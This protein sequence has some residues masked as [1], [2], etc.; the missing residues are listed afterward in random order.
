MSMPLILLIIALVSDMFLG[1]LDLGPFSLRVYVMWAMLAW[2]LM[3]TLSSQQSPLRSKEAHRLAVVYLVFIMWAMANRLYNGEPLDR[4]AL[5]IMKTHGMALTIFLVTQ[6]VVSNPRVAALLAKAMALTAIISGSVAIL[7]W[8]GIDWA[9]TLTVILHP[10]EIF[11]SQM[12]VV[13]RYFH[14]PGLALYSIPLSYHLSTFSIFYFALFLS[15]VQTKK[16]FLIKVSS[17]MVIIVMSIAVIIPQTRSAIF[18]AGSAL[19]FV[20]ISEFYRGWRFSQ[21]RLGLVRLF[22]ILLSFSCAVF[23]TYSLLAERITSTEA[24]PAEGGYRLGRVA[25][26]EDSQRL[27]LTSAA[28]QFIS[29][30]VLVGGGQEEFKS[31][32]GKIYEHQVSPH[33]MF[34]NCLV[35]YGL[36]GLALLL[37]LL[38]EIFQTCAKALRLNLSPNTR[39]TVLGAV[40]GLIA[41]IFNSMFHNDSFVSGGTLPWWLLGLLC[42]LISQER[43]RKLNYRVANGK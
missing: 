10:D 34:L 22:L 19:I 33:N 24:K 23:L 16:T 3:R 36:I 37:A 5:G 32:Q 1:D 42:G 43:G 12:M 28:L 25:E 11:S 6:A 8:W 18:A 4:I 29:K 38:R 17:F 15:Q 13:V 20:L 21:F 2:V 7:Q 26:L 31:H 40:G 9:W 41:Y 39:W 30:H 27:E 35:Y 14:A